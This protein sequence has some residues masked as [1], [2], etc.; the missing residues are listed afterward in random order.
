MGSCKVVTISK[1]TLS[2]QEKCTP[3]VTDF[4]NIPREAI[5][6]NRKR[7]GER[8]GGRKI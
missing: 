5:S 2:S 3:V 8:E 7:K 4:H 6:R 1:Y